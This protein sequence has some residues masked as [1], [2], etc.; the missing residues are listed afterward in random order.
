M[1]LFHCKCSRKDVCGICQD[2]DL[3]MVWIS[4]ELQF[5]SWHGYEIF[6][7]AIVSRLA[8]GLIQLLIQWYQCF[9][10]TSLG[11]AVK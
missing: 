6:L 5:D 2:S 7:L 4:K 8:M 10:I 9:F 1:V 3:G 11:A